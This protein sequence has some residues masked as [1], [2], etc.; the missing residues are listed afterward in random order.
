M[1]L[2][3]KYRSGRQNC[4]TGNGIP[5]VVWKTNL[6]TNPEFGAESSAVIDSFGNIYFGS[7]SGN[8]YSLDKFG[9]IRWTF[10]TKSKIYSSPLLLN[11]R[12]FFA[13]G[14][15]Y[16]Y[17]I[18]TSGEL[19]WKYD[20]GRLDKSKL[21]NKKKVLNLIHLPFT[22]DWRK[23]KNIIYKSWSSP[24]HIDEFLY[25]TGF[26]KGFYCFNHDGKLMWSYDLGFPRYQLSGVAI[27]E[28]DRIYCSSRAGKILS[29][30]KKGD[31]LWSKTIIRYWEPWGNPVVCKI[32][33]LVYFFFSWGEKKGII[34]ACN[35][36]GKKIWEQ[37]LGSIRGSCCI[38][39]EA[40]YIYCCDLNGFIYKIESSTGVIIKKQQ[41]TTAQRGL[42]ITPT[43]DKNG[44][45]LIATKDSPKDGR[46]LKLNA[47]LELIWEYKTNKVLSIP[48][49]LE[50][51][52]IIFGSWDGCYYKIKS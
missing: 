46:V 48:V 47:D 21:F 5:E 40:K 16:F 50:N 35:Y 36:G 32:N 25:I 44:D 23:G 39:W 43:I 10:T 27:D 4:E 3:D 26:G 18:C 51:K 42:W 52:E 33:K 41:L 17:C 37:S 19:K 28:N 13:G 6:K 7:H 8:F 12:I 14:D 20:L 49:I 11:G 22:Y 24:N 38:A 29:F 1:F 31:L 15:G 45:L 34:H 2:F 30:T 9:K